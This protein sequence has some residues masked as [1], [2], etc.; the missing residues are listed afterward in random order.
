MTAAADDPFLPAADDDLFLLKHP[1]LKRH[2]R[3]SSSACCRTRI[4]ARSIPEPIVAH[5]LSIYEP[6]SSALTPTP[7]CARNSA[8][9]EAGARHNSRWRGIHR[10]PA[11]R[12]PPGLPREATEK[13]V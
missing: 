8:L 4:F 9:S 2:S 5:E 10:R 6:L 3:T 7:R 11:R 12:A 13:R 1:R